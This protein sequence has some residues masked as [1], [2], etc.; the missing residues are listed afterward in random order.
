MEPVGIAYV[1]G[2]LAFRPCRTG[3]ELLRRDAREKR[4]VAFQID[5]SKALALVLMIDAE[6]VALIVLEEGENIVIGFNIENVGNDGECM[7]TVE[8]VRDS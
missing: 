4:N 5:G 1:S 8:V 6:A 3:L 7:A 2:R